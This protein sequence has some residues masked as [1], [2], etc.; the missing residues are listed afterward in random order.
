MEKGRVKTENRV[1]FIPLKTSKTYALMVGVQGIKIVTNSLHY[2][3]SAFYAMFLMYF[4]PHLYF[5]CALV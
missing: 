5:V 2:L 4:H 1:D 3:I